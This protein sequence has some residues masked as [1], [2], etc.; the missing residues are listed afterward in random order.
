MIFR[1]GDKILEVVFSVEVDALVV[2]NPL[3]ERN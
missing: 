1:E 2:G 3:A